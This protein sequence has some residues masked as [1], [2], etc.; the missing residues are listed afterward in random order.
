[1]TESF[2]RNKVPGNTR[3]GYA[4]SNACPWPSSK[5]A[6]SSRLC[7]RI[8]AFSIHRSGRQ[9]MPTN[10]QWFFRPLALIISAHISEIV[11]KGL[12]IFLKQKEITSQTNT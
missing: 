10:V 7:I 12:Y 1:M 4:I 2:N 11:L 3:A 9:V 6:D 5:S 8:Q